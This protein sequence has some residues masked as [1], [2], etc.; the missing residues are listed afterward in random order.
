MA[1]HL[2]Q[3]VDEAGDRGNGLARLAVGE[4]DLGTG[5]GLEQQFQGVQV[6]RALEQPASAS[7]HAALL[8]LPLEELQHFFQVG[9]DLA[10]VLAVEPSGVG[11]HVDVGVH[12][13]QEGM[14]HEHELFVGLQGVERVDGEDLRHVLE[15]GRDFAPGALDTHAR[16][17]K[18]LPGQRRRVACFP[19]GR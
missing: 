11:G 6:L 7:R 13:A 4:D 14:L 2:P 8:L 10:L 18:C 3:G 5:E 9:V 16:L 19:P 17:L 12:G 1:V 15:H